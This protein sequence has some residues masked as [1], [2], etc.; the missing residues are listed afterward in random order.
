MC[1]PDNH[2]ERVERAFNKYIVRLPECSECGKKIKDDFL[3]DIGDMLF[4]VECIDK[5]IAPA[6]DYYE[7]EKF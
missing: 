5:N 4:C 6:S 3:Y 7:E 2:D 1:A